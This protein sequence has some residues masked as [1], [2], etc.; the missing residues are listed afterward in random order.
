MNKIYKDKSQVILCNTIRVLLI[1]VSII[2]LFPIIGEI[3]TQ[4]NIALFFLNFC[5]FLPLLIK[6]K[7]ENFYLFEPI[8]LFAFFFAFSFLLT[9]IPLYNANFMEKNSSLYFDPLNPGNII[10]LYSLSAGILCF[11]IGYFCIEVLYKKKSFQKHNNISLYKIEKF[12]KIFCILY[13]ISISFRLY[14]Y[15]RGFLGSLSAASNIDVSLP[16]KSIW[17]FI[18]NMWPIYYG[19]FA[20]LSF[21]NTK[22]TTYLFLFIL[23]MELFFMLISGD[24]RNI[25]ILIAT[26]FFCFYLMRKN[27]TTQPLIHKNISKKMD[28][29][30]FLQS[31]FPFRT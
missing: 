10:V 25:L 24:R 20:L 16:L 5:I 8:Y 12:I 31:T 22:K 14:G 23:G 4:F 13:T 7:K 19:Y 1:T 29:N 26:Y 30:Y 28:Y 21:K 11:Y 9:T 18:S 17:Y 27:V 6:A 2:L 3:N 15:Y